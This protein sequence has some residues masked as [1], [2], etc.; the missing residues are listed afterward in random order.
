LRR[1]P[2]AAAF[3]WLFLRAT[4]FEP[5]I[6]RM[7]AE[8][9]GKAQARKIGQLPFNTLL[10]NLRKSASSAVPG[11]CAQAGENPRDAIQDHGRNGPDDESMIGAA[12]C[13]ACV[14]SVRR[15]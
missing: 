5:R 4:D 7:S 6:S 3:C 15:F 1:R 12:R 10:Q 9:I 14:S 8:R 13:W 2:A 11:L